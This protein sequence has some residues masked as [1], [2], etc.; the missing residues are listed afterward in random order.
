MQVSHS[1]VECFTICPFKYKLTYLDKLKTFKDD[2]HDNSL[3]LGHALHVCLQESI[4]RGLDDYYSNYPVIDDK[5]INEAIKLQTIAKKARGLLPEGGLVEVEIDGDDYKGY[6]DYLV[7]NDQGGFDLYDFK[8]CNAKNADKYLKSPQLHLY[9]YFF[10]I[11]GKGRIDNLFY[12]IVPKTGIRQKKTETLEQFRLR[13]Y[14]ECE[15]IEPYLLPVD[16]DPTKVI[17]F[18]TNTK[19]LIECECFEK[20]ESGLCNWCEFEGFCKNG[21]ETMLLPSTARRELATTKY[22]KLWIYGAPFTGKTFF[23][24]KF[25]VPLMLNTDGNIKFVDAPFVAIKDQVTVEG[26]LTNRKFAWEVFE[27]AVAELEKGS[28]FKTIIVDLV[29]DV[30]EAC[31]VYMYDQL[32]IT[33]ESDDSFRAYDKIRSRFL[34]TLKR[35]LN[36]EADVIL[37]SHEDVSRDLTKKGGDKTTQFKPNIADKL[38]NKIAGMVDIVGRCVSEGEERSM[39]FKKSEMVFGGGRITNIKRKEIPLEYETFIGIY[40]KVAEAPKAVE[41]VAQA[42]PVKVEEPKVEEPVKQAEEPVKQP[43]PEPVKAE[44]TP[45]PV[46]QA[47]DA[48]VR[49]RK[50]RVKVE[51]STNDEIPF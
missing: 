25:P 1:K 31:R 24:N 27:E 37:I 9:K 10:E 40:P 14:S 47:E 13:I 19:H 38:A 30:Y 2:A 45:E 5:V 17:E 15:K 41:P 8:Y 3:Y 33:H 20:K 48:P 6:I 49:K 16:Y 34:N 32:G 28:D 43:D 29:E 11:L 44:P 39:T 46:K 50:R 7:P 51:E 22:H 36:I 35:L 21:D 42:E 23:A 4:E 18:L 26:R 12:L